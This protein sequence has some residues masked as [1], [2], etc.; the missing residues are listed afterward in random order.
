[1]HP[2][3][4]R[5]GPRVEAFYGASRKPA[6]RSRCCS[7]GPLMRY[8][9]DK[10]VH[11]TFA[12]EGESGGRLSAL[13]AGYVDGRR[14]LLTLARFI[15]NSLACAPILSFLRMPDGSE[16]TRKDVPGV[17]LEQRARGDEP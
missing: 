6:E 16:F 8:L 17:R 4:W 10:L 13:S 3:L 11:D 1:M 12:S 5:F 15:A 2:L 14:F 7:C 9:V